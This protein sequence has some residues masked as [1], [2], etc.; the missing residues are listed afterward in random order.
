MGHLH[1][2]S[3]RT[4]GCK[5]GRRTYARQPSVCTDFIKLVVDELVLTVPA[6]KLTDLL[7][8]LL[9]GGVQREAYA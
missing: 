2:M 6:V 3:D 7:A 9:G 8:N 5:K 1:Y 4:K